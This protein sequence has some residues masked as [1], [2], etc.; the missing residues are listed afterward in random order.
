MATA[1]AEAIVDPVALVSAAYHSVLA[2]QVE[3]SSTM[4]VVAFNDM[5]NQ[6]RTAN[7]GDGG[8]L[9]IRPGGAPLATV[10][11][12]AAAAA[13][14]TAKVVYR[15]PPQEHEFGRPFQLGHHDGSDA[16]SA[17]YMRTLDVAA[18]DVVVLGTDGLFDNVSNEV[19]VEIVARETVLPLHPSNAA[20]S[21]AGRRRERRVALTTTSN[22]L[23]ERAFKNSVNKRCVTP[24]SVA[25]SEEFNLVFNGGKKDDITVVIAHIGAADDA[26]GAA[27]DADE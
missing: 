18:G 2:S 14:A 13:A 27:D 4:C 26:I 23:L 8:F 10:G 12:A 16:P 6:L 3:G 11:T 25:A 5:L 19:I 9:V 17:A 20:E 22:V 1:A 21:V 24:Y 7:I 15:S